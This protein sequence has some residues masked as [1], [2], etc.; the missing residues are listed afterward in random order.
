MGHSVLVK[1]FAR[2]LVVVHWVFEPD[3]VSVVLF[4]VG[5]FM[6]GI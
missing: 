1:T 5:A 6:S 4:D 3:G 2:N